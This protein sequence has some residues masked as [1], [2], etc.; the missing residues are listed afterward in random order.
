MKKS[1]IAGCILSAAA[2]LLIGAAFAQQD[3]AT[4]AQPAPAATPKHTPDAKAHQGL[5]TDKEKQSYAVGMNLGENLKSQSVDIDPNLLL[6]GM[7]DSMAGGKTLLTQDE[8]HATL[9]A[10]QTGLRKTM[11][12][13]MQ[14]VADKNKTEGAAFLATNKSKPGV[15]TLPSGL[16]YKILQPGTGPKPTSSDSVSTNYRGTLI[17]GTEFDS[18]YKRGQAATFPVTGVIKGW[19]E[20]LQLMPVGSKWQL[21]VPASL[22]YGDKAASPVLGPNAT[23]IFDVELISIKEKGAAAE[24]APAP[25]KK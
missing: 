19:T 5:T 11:M 12:E 14:K 16:Q 2:M 25:E 9:M 23:L 7:K 8:E 1:I 17:D 4:P 13:K 24:K 18:S 22:A 6:K 3:A 15:V 10:L 21:Y 20:A